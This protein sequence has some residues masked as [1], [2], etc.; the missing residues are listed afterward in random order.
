MASRKL[1]SLR[2]P[3]PEPE[4]AEAPAPDSRRPESGTRLPRISIKML[5][6]LMMV[7]AVAFAAYGGMRKGIKLEY[8]V[9]FATAAPVVVLLIVGV[10]HQWLRRR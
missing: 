1:P 8:Y 9:M 5:M 6:M 3:E 7:V 2:K 10:F 4:P